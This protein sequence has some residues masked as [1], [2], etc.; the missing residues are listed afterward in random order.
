LLEELEDFSL[1]GFEVQQDIQEFSERL[2]KKY[3]NR[4]IEVIYAAVSN[5]NGKIEYFEP[6]TWGKNYKGSTTVVA[7]KK[8]LGSGYLTPR[9]APAIDFSAWLVEKF[10]IG[11]FLFVKMD[12]EGAEYD[13]IE[14]LLNTGA[15][16]LI[17][18]LAVEWHAD[19][20][21]EPQATR[22]RDIEN[23]V[24][25]YAKSHSVTLLNWY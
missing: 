7:N 9:V 5:A 6:D 20:F 12:I 8:A 25:A 23:R 14:S 24:S 11:D 1:R 16:D 3:S 22:Y 2:K 13:V 19:K 10:S 17:D 15:I 4:D 21:E 18:V